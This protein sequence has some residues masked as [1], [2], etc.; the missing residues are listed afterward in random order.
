MMVGVYVILLICREL[1][2]KS[3]FV[4]LARGGSKRLPNKNLIPFNNKPLIYWSIQAALNSKIEK[5]LYVSSDSDDILSISR[6][7]GALTY[8]RPYH[9]SRSETSSEDSLYDIACFLKNSGR[10]YDYICLLQPTSPLRNCQHID[11]AFSLLKE[12]GSTSLLSSCTPATLPQKYFSISSNKI[13]FVESD[14]S[15]QYYYPNGAIYITLFNS[16]LASKS[17]YEP[18]ISTYTMNIATSVDIDTAHDLNLAMYYHS[19]L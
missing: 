5:D 2:T 14:N 7:F 10:Q 19:L 3:L 18:P 15:L 11:E 8:K 17:L 4:I 16:F 13:S 1:M 12:S 9:L 6:S